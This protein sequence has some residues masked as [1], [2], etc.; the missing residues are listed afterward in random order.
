L[1]D[2]DDHHLSLDFKKALDNA[3]GT[4]TSHKDRE[5]N[6]CSIEPFVNKGFGAYGRCLE[7]HDEECSQAVT[8][9]SVKPDAESRWPFSA[10]RRHEAAGERHKDAATARSN[11]IA[12]EK[13]VETNPE[14]SDSDDRCEVNKAA[15]LSRATFI[16]LGT[17]GHSFERPLPAVQLSSSSLLRL[18]RPHMLTIGGTRLAKRSSDLRKER[19]SIPCW[20]TVD[21]GECFSHPAGRKDSIRGMWLSW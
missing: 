11:H 3:S 18:A 4:K 19:I 21:V 6:L 13:E 5:D 15:F 16:G 17:A 1:F 8:F 9:G 10:R 12:F 20:A 14:V 7:G 2:C